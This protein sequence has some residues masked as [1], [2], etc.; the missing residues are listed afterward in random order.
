VSASPARMSLGNNLRIRLFRRNP[1]HFW[2]ECY[3]GFCENR[4]PSDPVFEGR[5][6]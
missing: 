6:P 1:I 4:A 2:L 5:E 3:G